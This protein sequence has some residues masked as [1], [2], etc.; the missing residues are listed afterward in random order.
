MLWKFGK[1]YSH[2]YNAYC[3]QEDLVAISLST[4]LS[5]LQIA[6][7]LEQGEMDTVAWETAI[8]EK[9]AQSD[10]SLPEPEAVFKTN[11]LV[12]PSY[13]NTVIV[14][15]EKVQSRKKSFEALIQWLPSYFINIVSRLSSEKMLNSD[16]ES[17]ENVGI[18]NE[19]V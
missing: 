8:T 6:V 9:V 2:I 7:E 18:K 4:S 16:N 10:I 17:V 5:L 15:F 14:G 12:K 1:L 13:S 11:L 3:F 19:H